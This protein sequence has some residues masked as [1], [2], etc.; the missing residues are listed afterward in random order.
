MP[1]ANTGLWALAA[2][3]L[4]KITASK[5]GFAPE[6]VQSLENYGESG[7]CPERHSPRRRPNTKSGDWRALRLCWEVDTSSS[8][9]TIVPAQI[10]Q[11]PI[12]GRNYL[13]LLQT[14]ARHRYQ[15]PARCKA[16]MV[17]RPFLENVGG[18]AVF[19]IDGMPNRDEVNGG[20]GGTI[21][22]GT[23]F[24]NFRL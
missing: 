22:S 24:W 2:G 10:E 11:M 6:T 16:W 14:G 17:R 20:R 9:A 13:D 23:R 19:L 12:N 7:H 21:Q 8:G 15:P 5:V 3:G 4:C 1:L 18:N